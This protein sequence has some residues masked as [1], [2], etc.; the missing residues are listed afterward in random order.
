M[1]KRILA[2]SDIH[3]NY[4]K[5]VELLDFANYNSKEDHLV[6]CGDIVDR[7]NQNMKTLFYVRDLVKE[8]AVKPEHVDIALIKQECRRNGGIGTLETEKMLEISEKKQKEFLDDIDKLKELALKA[9]NKLN[10]KE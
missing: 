1:K 3:G 8:G 7:G 4:D 2:I 6:I 9:N 10:G 5:L